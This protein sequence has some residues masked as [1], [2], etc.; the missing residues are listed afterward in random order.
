MR[1]GRVVLLLVFVGLW[2][3][4]A[5][6]AM[7]DP[8]LR[9][10]CQPSLIEDWRAA[11]PT[12]VRELSHR[13]DAD[14]VRINLRWSESE[15]RPGVYDGDY[16]G[17]A[18][19]AAAAL[20]AEGVQVI[21]VVYGTPTWASDRSL[22][23]TAAP[24]DAAGRYHTYYPP[25][26]K[27]LG[28][29][30]AFMQHLSTKLAGK[31]LG[32]SCWIEPNMWTYFYPQ[33]R[34]SDAGFGPHRYARMLAA[35]AEGVRAGDPAAQVIAGETSPTG[36]NTVL[37]TSPVRFARLLR[38]AGCASLF[39]AYAHHPYPVGGTKAIAPGAMPRDVSRTVNLANLDALLRLFP[40]K[41]FYLTEYGY[42][43]HDNM[44]FGVSVD[45]ITQAAYL[46]RAFEY[47]QRYAQVK[48][49]LWFPCRDWSAT[50]TY[51]YRFGVYTG[52]RA[53]SG[54]KKRAYYAFAGQNT[55]TLTAPESIER[56]DVLAL[57]GTLTSGTMGPLADKPLVVEGRKQGGSWVIVTRCRTRS[58]GS[59][60]VR[61]QPVS[62]AD[63]RVRWR[64]VASS[65]A[66]WVGV[67]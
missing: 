47:V 58:D 18:A 5:P 34:A 38:D 60:V 2:A 36:D 51:R 50:G 19:K 56:G 54:R 67:S 37:R 42:A 33:R 52:L 41:P 10:A 26:L 43:T 14:V 21:V 31:V 59:Y 61:V 63:W 20:H 1:A 44:L 11:G 29:F 28:R 39:D 35:F 24:G 55:L 4:L 6:A 66:C 40:D 12:M 32:Y 15:H 22:W 64:G 27:K 7:A 25:S 46:Q 49:L 62:G 17:R 48:L 13:L 8:V 45:E 16:L 9:G 53:L 23:K 3:L 65:P 57:R 30:R